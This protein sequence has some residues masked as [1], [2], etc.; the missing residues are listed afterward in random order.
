MRTR[1]VQA[2]P[3]RQDQSPQAGGG[4]KRGRFD[5]EGRVALVTGG[6]G[7]IGSAVALGLAEHGADVS[8]TDLDLDRAE[9]VAGRIRG[10]G[11]R[12]CALVCDVRSQPQIDAAVA[13]MLEQLG[14][15]DVLVHTAGYG[16]L[17][18]LLEMPLEEFEANLA[19]FL[20]SGF[21]ISQAVG[22]VMVRQGTGGSI[23]HVSSIASARALGRGTGAYAAAKAGLNALVRESAVEWAPHGIRVNAVGP[24]QIRTP[25]LDRLLDS[26]LHG[27]REALT[28]RIISRIPL[29]RLGEPDEIAG[30]CIF[31]ASDAA[32][33]VTGQVLFVDGGNTAF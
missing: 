27:G 9:P 14:R 33:L 21:L 5:L 31:L 25:S 8:V 26:G 15:I 3:Q 29:G 7:A 4:R 17:K 28:Q 1:A 30:P 32:S 16:V 18:P 23:V 12:A 13:A 6:A 19:A 11:R 10:L 2:D 24:C 20:T 22:R